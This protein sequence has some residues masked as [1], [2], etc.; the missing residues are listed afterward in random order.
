MSSEVKEP[1]VTAEFTSGR[2]SEILDDT[3]SENVHL[4]RRDVQECS[5]GVWKFF[6]GK[7]GIDRWPNEI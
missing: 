3:L 4:R 5:F 2:E 7:H 6:L 1:I